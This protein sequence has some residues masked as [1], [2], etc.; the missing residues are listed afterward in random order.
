MAEIMI[1][2][3]DVDS[4]GPQLAFYVFQLFIV[5]GEPF[6]VYD[7]RCWKLNDSFRFFILVL[8]VQFIQAV[9]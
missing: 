9:I 7:D 5:G 2:S 1:A 4:R 3:L 8:Y 6:L